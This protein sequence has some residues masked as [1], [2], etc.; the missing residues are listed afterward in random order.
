MTNNET[1][2]AELKQELDSVLDSLQRNDID[3]D[4]ALKSYERGMEL[5]GLLEAKLKSA[6]NKI[7]KLKQKFDRV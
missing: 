2:Y 5:I 7:T 4:D 3:V 1:S 6:E